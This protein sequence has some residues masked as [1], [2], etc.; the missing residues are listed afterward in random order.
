[1][2]LRRLIRINVATQISLCLALGVLWLQVPH[3][4]RAAERLTIMVPAERGGGWDL[5]AQAMEAAL[6]SADLVDSVEIEYSPGAGG[7]IGLAQF[8]SSRASDPNAL[9]VTG[10]FTV[11][12]VIQNH[13]A[14]SLLDAT[15][16]ARLTFDNAVVAVPADSQFRTADDLIE[17]ML[18]TPQSVTWVGG[19]RAGVDEINLHEFARSLSIAPSRLN[20]TGL[21]GGGEVSS[22]LAAGRYMAGISGY[23]EF[24]QLV[25]DGRLRILAVV[26][27][28]GLAEVD[29][30]SFARLGIKVERLNWR[31][32]IAPPGLTPAEIE[33]LSGLVR[34]MVET[35]AWQQHVARHHWIDA[36]LAGPEFAEFIEAEQGRV[37]QDLALMKEYGPLD[38][39][40]VQSVLFRRYAWAIA[41]A[42]ISILLLGGLIYQRHVA[43]R[44]EQGLKEAYEE[45][46]GKAISQTEE[47][48]KALTS[49]HDQIALEFDNWNLTAAEREIALL[50]LKGLRLKEIAGS[51]GTSERTV[52]QQAQAIYKKAG[53]EGRFELAAYFI[54]DVIQSMELETGTAPAP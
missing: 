39:D 17:T 29:A 32:V 14:V 31:G 50:L 11:G 53:L 47:L 52:R 30:P 34:R 4:A 5:T 15:P 28:E 33:A 24:E 10:M 18:T 8:V 21:P 13:A 2:T 27:E 6:T 3:S 36:Y 41:L 12:S 46:T 1:M 19:S 54:E 20:Y 37:A 48:E 44:R 7:A 16:L 22:A 38:S 23:S 9:L 45:A 26:N 43:R 35:P 42:G 51:R 40:I 25:V 49:I